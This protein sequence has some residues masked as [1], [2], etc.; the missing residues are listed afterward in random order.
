MS[1]KENYKRRFFNKKNIQNLFYEI[2]TL[3]AGSA[4]YASSLTVFLLPSQTV[5]GGIAGIATTL[6]ILYDTNVGLVIIVLNIPLV[7]FALK[8]FG[9]RFLS[10]TIA[11]IVIS[12]AATDLLT[13]LPVTLND[14]LLCALMGGAV[15]GIGTGVMMT[16]GYNTGGS[17]LAGIMLSHK[18][19]RLSTGRTI[20]IID[21]CI[22]VGSAIA[23]SNYTGI[24]YSLI[25][26]ASY[27]F[28]VDLVLDGS[29]TAKLTLIIS[30]KY[31]IISD[32][33]FRE[34]DR[35]VTILNGFGWYSH[36]DKN[37]IM[38]VVKRQELYILKN[39]VKQ[40]D[41][42]AFMILSDAKEVMG[43]GFSELS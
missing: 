34:L 11:T 32:A 28:A 18:I 14:P 35:G 1:A 25:A 31:D 17:D 22:I 5:M 2:G 4:L 15:M 36:M 27:S 3:L 38:C 12:S 10:K 23:T 21:F 9:F 8:T 42:S 6:N 13:F 30:D 39:V 43:Y 40:A 29:R 7:L 37:V 41:S 20:L 26:A 16:R 33:I 19:K 24:L